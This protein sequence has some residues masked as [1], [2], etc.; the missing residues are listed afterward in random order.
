MTSYDWIIGLALMFGLALVMNKFTFET[1]AG[2]FVFLTIF[3]GFVV[4]ANLLPLWSLI[5]NIVV[6]SIVM[7]QELSN[8]KGIE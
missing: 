1:L 6:L 4:Y 3:N 8:K 2:F 5:L 7:Y